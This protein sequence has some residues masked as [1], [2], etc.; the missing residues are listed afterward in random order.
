DRGELFSLDPNHPNCFA[1]HKRPFHTIIPAFITEAGRPWMSFGVMGGDMQPQGHTQIVCNLRDFG[2]NA[3]EAG[4]APRWFHD[5]SSQPTGERM[6]DGGQVF[7]ES[8]YGEDVV[9]ALTALGH[10]VTVQAGQYG[11]YQGIRYDG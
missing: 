9:R 7:V 11:G 2:M 1:P 5:G 3:Q 8:G 4:D 10:R 6:S